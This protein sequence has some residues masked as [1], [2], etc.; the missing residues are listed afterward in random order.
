[1][2]TATL[3]RFTQSTTLAVG[4][5]AVVVTGARAATAAAPNAPP[6]ARTVDVVDQRFGVTAPD[7]YRWMEGNDNPEL[8]AFLRAQGD[9]ARGWLARLPGRDALLRRVRDAIIQLHR[10]IG[11]P[12]AV[13]QSIA[14]RGQEGRSV[15]PSSLD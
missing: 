12:G 8:T 15:S 5:A 1:M 10:E 3:R 2:R 4:L 14:E 13:T 7:P 6:P 9:Y 11:G